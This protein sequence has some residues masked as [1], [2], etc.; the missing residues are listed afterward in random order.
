M[1]VFKYSRRHGTKAA[2]MEGQ[3]PESKKTKRSEE[4]IALG[5]EMSREY[6]EY[7]LGKQVSVLVEEQMEIDGVTYWTGFTKEYIRVAISSEKNLANQ[8]VVGEL[9]EFVTDEVIGMDSL[10]LS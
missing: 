3:I 4:L 2:T 1:H 5:K 8:I 9:K 10:Q 7:F 6:R